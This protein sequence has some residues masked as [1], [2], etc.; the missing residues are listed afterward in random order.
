MRSWARPI[1]EWRTPGLV[2]LAS[3]ELDVERLDGE[4]HELVVVGAE[5]RVALHHF[6]QRRVAA[7][8]LVDERG[9]AQRV[10]EGRVRV[11]EH[12]SLLLAVDHGDVGGEVA[13][14]VLVPRVR[15]QQLR[16]R[17]EE[18]AAG[19]LEG[20]GAPPFCVKK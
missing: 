13:V 17:L 11:D 3:A 15:A 20:E 8:R 2:A 16:R 14:G 10:G 12:V 6:H 9:D 18:E 1:F 5:P 19:L 4:T 7:G